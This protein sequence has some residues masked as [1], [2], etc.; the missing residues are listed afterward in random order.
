MSQALE[1]L[2][3]EER[4]FPPSAE[5]AAQA[6]AQPGIHEEAAA[7]FVGFWRRQA[8]ERISWFTEPTETLDDSN[9][10]FY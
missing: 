9:P 4:T 7:D 5:F 1:N 6:N 3:H 8:L 10:P 2:L